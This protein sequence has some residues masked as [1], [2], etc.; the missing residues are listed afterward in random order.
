MNS[1]AVEFPSLPGETLIRNL[2][3]FIARQLQQQGEGDLQYKQAII[4]TLC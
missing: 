4:H 1:D 2:T 3:A